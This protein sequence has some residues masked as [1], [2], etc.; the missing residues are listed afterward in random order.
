MVLLVWYKLSMLDYGDSACLGRDTSQ[1]IIP[2]GQ[3]H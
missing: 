2:L 3:H 1:R